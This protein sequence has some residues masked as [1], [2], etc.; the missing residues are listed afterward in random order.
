MLKW[1]SALTLVLI[2]LLISAIVV[3]ES[4]FGEYSRAFGSLSQARFHAMNAQMDA[5]GQLARAAY[6]ATSLADL[7]LIVVAARA[8]ARLI[9]GLAI[10]LALALTL[11]LLVSLASVGPAMIG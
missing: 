9:C 7:A 3:G 10:A 2:A 4:V 1:L 5:L 11:F 6:V 8:R